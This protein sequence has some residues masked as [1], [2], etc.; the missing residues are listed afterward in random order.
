M[1]L[2]FNKKKGKNGKVYQSI[3]LC[4]KYRENG[5]P[6]TKVVLNLS[7]MPQ[8]VID[9]F[10]ISF[11]KVKQKLVDIT[12]IIIKKSIDYGFVYLIFI[13]MERLRINEVIEKCYC[14][15]KQLIKLMII[16]KIVTRG[17]KLCILNW[18]KRNDFIS[19]KLNIDSKKLKVDHLY[20]ELGL[21]SVFQEKIERKWFLYN[22]SRHDNLFL[23]DITS[24]YFEGTENELAAF[25]YN[26]DGKKG[27]LQITIGL[28]TDNEGFPLK[29]EVFKGNTVDHKTTRQQLQKLK[30]K[31]GAKKLIMVGDRGM[32]LR[33]NLEEM[34]EKQGMGIDYISAL[35]HDEIRSL[36]KKGIVQLNLFS[37]ELIEIEKENKRYILC[38]NPILEKEQEEIRRRLRD[39]FEAEIDQIRQSWQKRHEQ[40]LNNIKRL[41][42]GDKNKKLVTRFSDKKLDNYKFRAVTALKKYKMTA[43]YS[44]EINNDEFQV[45]FEVDKYQKEGSLNGKYVIETSVSKSM[46]NKEQIRQEYKNLQKVE[47]GFRDLKTERLEVRPV[48]HRNEAQTRGHIFITMFAYAIIK[49][50]ETK[51]FPW[52][53]KYNKINKR[54][55]SF[56]DIEEELKDIKLCELQIGNNKPEIKIPE[57]NEIQTQVLTLF[58]IKPHEI[59]T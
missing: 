37:K 4:E 51:I 25:G 49:E 29:I 26:R 35:T 57:L 28:I 54:Q 56:A 34:T 32:R 40:N 22:K 23:Y 27:K 55:I 47:H 15:D 24:T 13:L 58:K 17:S 43:F 44:I 59:I 39:S 48:F 9:A 6:K 52:L 46:M 33:V 38:N 2:Q 1:Y 41:A 30:E 10:K 14:G 53:K 12:D 11:S 19:M 36:L 18:I 5:I 21:L 31:Y 42:A 7:K 50:M 3:L 8:E 20:K 45:S 16:G